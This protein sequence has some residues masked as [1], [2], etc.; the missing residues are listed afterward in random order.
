MI[1]LD[2]KSLSQKIIDG[3]KEKVSTLS[4]P[5][6]LDII[7][8]GQDA[9][10]LKYVAMKQKKA[11]SIG[12]SGQIIQL[13]DTATTSQIIH[14]TN[15]LNHDPAVSA[16]MVQLPLP[17]S[18]DSQ[19][20]L[21]A[22]DP[23]KDADGL[24]PINLGKLFTQDP[25][26]IASATPLGILRLLQNYQI[27]LS[28]KNAVIIGRSPIVGLPLFALLN[29]A[30]ATVTMCHSHTADLSQICQTADI[31]VS[32]VGK[33]KFITSD[34]VKSGAIVVDVGT[35]YDQNGQLSGDVDFD[36]VASRCSYITPVPGG[37]GPMTIACLLENAL[38]LS[39]YS[40]T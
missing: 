14:Q 25:T 3:L 15:L 34:M 19:K 40:S 38:T 2:G 20:I 24:N 29:N 22:I 28:G 23:A 6:R 16:F 26:A 21:L 13:P 1:L 32:A 35:H 11:E 9:A 17:A 12:I 8:V 5:P 33:P 4:F 30:N 37:V 39:K 18:V 27:D 10:S 7:L 31:L 36:A